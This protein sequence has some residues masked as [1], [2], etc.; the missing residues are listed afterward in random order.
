[1]IGFVTF[2]RVNH[3]TYRWKVIA[4]LNRKRGKEKVKERVSG[5]NYMC[6]V[7]WTA[8]VYQGDVM[9]ALVPGSVRI[10]LFVRE[11]LAHSFPSN[12]TSASP[13]M[14]SRGRKGD[15]RRLDQPQEHTKATSKQTYTPTTGEKVTT[16]GRFYVPPSN[17]GG[18]VHSSALLIPADGV[19]VGMAWHR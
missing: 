8:R 3:A 19:T 7:A 9:R 12:P 1:M 6:Q 14:P 13:G 5:T 17:C 10:P 2:K 18:Q 11:C 4:L 16:N 15:W